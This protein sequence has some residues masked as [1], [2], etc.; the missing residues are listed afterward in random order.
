MR[1]AIE[2]PKVVDLAADALSLLK[3]SRGRFGGLCIKFSW[4]F[5]KAWIETLYFVFVMTCHR[6]VSR[7]S[8]QRPP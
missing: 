1:G 6:P 4:V 3:E 7:L 2:M 8:N 5:R